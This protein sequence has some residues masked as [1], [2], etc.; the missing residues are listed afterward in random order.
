MSGDSR[1]LFAGGDFPVSQGL[2]FTAAEEG[3]TIC[4]P[5]ERQNATFVRCGKGQHRSRVETPESDFA[6]SVAGR[7]QLAIG[8]D[9]QRQPRAS[10]LDSQFLTAVFQIPGLQKTVLRDACDR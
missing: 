6:L 1:A 3:F 2:V 4:A 8:R 9:R 7:D 5:G 10:Q